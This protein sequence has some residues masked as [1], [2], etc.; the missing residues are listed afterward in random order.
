MVVQFVGYN[1]LSLFLVWEWGQS[2]TI[3]REKK[4]SLFI[5]YSALLVLFLAF[6]T[7]AILPSL[8]IYSVPAVGNVLG[9]GV[10]IAIWYFIT[11]YQLMQINPSLA[12]EII[13]DKITDMVILMDPEGNISRV[14]PRLEML[15]GF[16]Q[17]SLR[18]RH[19]ST[20][21]PNQG[22]QKLLHNK[23]DFLKLQHE[24]KSM[25]YPVNQKIKLHYP[26]R[27]GDT[28]P[29][30]AL[31]SLIKSEEEI[32]GF[33]LVAQDQRQTIKLKQEIQKKLK[34]QENVKRHLKALQSLNELIVSMNQIITRRNYWPKLWIP[35]WIY[36]NS[37]KEGFT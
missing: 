17:S 15:L 5:F 23:I 1:L 30:E 9:M 35:L 33:T 32:A 4:Q 22:E 18:G 3:N 20:F 36:W 27:K 6:F 10:I 2:T 25:D 21:I 24:K 26:T 11:H 13:M 28:I 34:A 19:W 16:P 7:N 14:N 31:I 12:G 8:A 37:K 29:V